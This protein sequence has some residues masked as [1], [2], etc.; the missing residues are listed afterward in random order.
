MGTV[1]TIVGLGWGRAT[2]PITAQDVLRGDT[3]TEITMG[4]LKAEPE[5]EIT[6]I[7]DEE[8]DA[9]LERQTLFNPKAVAKYVSMWI[10]G[11]S[12]SL[13]LSFLFF[14]A[15]PMTG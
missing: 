11:P 10:I 5:S 14:T 15:F 9:T 8:S 12:I 13:T 1:M 2:R 4:A 7:G 6:K 3:E